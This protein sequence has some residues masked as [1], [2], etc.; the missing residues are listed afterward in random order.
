MAYAQRLGDCFLEGDNCMK[1][2]GVGPGAPAASVLL[3]GSFPCARGAGH[4]SSAGTPLS[5]CNLGVPN[6]FCCPAAGF[7]GGPCSVARAPR[8]AWHAR[9]LPLHEQRQ[10]RAGRRAGVCL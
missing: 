4:F 9:S 1:L 7:A 3:A 2:P 5:L 10:G 6:D 8:H